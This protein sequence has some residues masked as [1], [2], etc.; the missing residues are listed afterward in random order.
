[1]WMMRLTIWLAV[2]A[3][4]LRVF[5]EAS[6]REFAVRDRLMRW[7]WLIGA[8]ACVVHV[9]CAMGFAHCWN[10]ANAM[11]HTGQITRHVVGV[12]LPESVFVNFA[13]TALWVVDA[14]QEFRLNQPNRLGLARQMTWS[15][16]MLNATVVFGPSYWI[17]LA[18]PFIAI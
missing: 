12:E 8:V 18:I 9:V 13:F 5:V 4:L 7:T 3:W 14:V 2:A 17:W 15:V 11:R 10:L 16:M 6:G 1:M